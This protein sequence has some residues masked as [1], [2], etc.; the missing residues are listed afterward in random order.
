MDIL[1]P[2]I[3]ILFNILA[4]YI[5]YIL[6]HFWSEEEDRRKT[7]DL[8]VQSI[9]EM[10]YMYGVWSRILYDWE[11][12][13][14]GKYFVTN[15]IIL[16]AELLV[17]YIRSKNWMSETWIYCIIWTTRESKAYLHVYTYSSITGEILHF[18]N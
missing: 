5:L 15:M 11:E 9:D 13:F 2:S 18:W 3:D 14:L 12:T 16:N 7:C 6:Y 4:L 10:K 1:S 17:K 8:S